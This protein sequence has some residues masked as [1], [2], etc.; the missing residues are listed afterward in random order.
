MKRI[1]RRY[2]G[3]YFVIKDTLCC[4]QVF[5]FFP[6]GKGY[7]IIAS[8]KCA[9][10][11]DEDG[12]ANVECREEDEE[13]FF[14]YFDLARDYS[15][16]VNSAKS[17]NAGILAAAAQE[18][19]GIRILNQDPEETLFS[20]IVSQN[21]NIPRIKGIIERLCLA[22]GEERDFFGEKYMAFPTASRLAEKDE[23]FFKSAGL[24]YRAE[25]V[26]RLAVEIASGLDVRQ[27]GKLSTRELKNRLLSI[28]GVGR[29]VA[30]CV[31][32]FGYRKSDSF[33]VD[34][35]LEKV[36]RED[37]GGELK[38]R[39]KIAEYF[40]ERFGENS[41]Y[42]QQYLFYHKRGKE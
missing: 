26:R 7:K 29:K 41:G 4:G 20:F 13:F 38:N 27:F 34:T 35:W 8:D 14:E 23:E 1:K 12:K 9:Y 42:Y 32:L 17:E 10:V 40:S 31:A 6:Y 37:F 22:L 18:G 11:Y 24:G 21:N 3:E 16:I 25:Y 2:D 39:E 30:D 5:R 19:K 15:A 28:Y 36:Y 33:P